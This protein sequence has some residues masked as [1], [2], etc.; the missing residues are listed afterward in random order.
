MDGSDDAYADT[1]LFTHLSYGISADG[2]VEFAVHKHSEWA[3]GRLESS[4]FRAVAM[5]RLLLSLKD[6]ESFLCK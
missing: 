4:R 5:L 3:S 1:D 2:V 6:R